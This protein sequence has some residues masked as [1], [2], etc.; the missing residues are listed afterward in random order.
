MVLSG[1]FDY[2][3]SDSHDVC[4]RRACPSNIHFNLL[5]NLIKDLIGIYKEA[6]ETRLYDLVLCK[7]YFLGISLSNHMVQWCDRVLMSSHGRE[8]QLIPGAP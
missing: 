6:V 2:S 5:W 7:V 8:A 4:H 1:S 3:G